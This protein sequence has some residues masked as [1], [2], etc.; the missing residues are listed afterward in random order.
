MEQ[1]QVAE[2]A[3]ELLR[4]SFELYGVPSGTKD[5]LY[6]PLLAHLIEPARQAA[7]IGDVAKLLPPGFFDRHRCVLDLGCGPGTFTIGLNSLGHAAYGIDLDPRKIALAHAHVREGGH[8]AQWCD[9]LIPGDGN[10]LPFESGSFDVVASY[11]VLEHVNDLRSVLCEAVRVTKPGGFLHLQ[12]PDYRYSY[13]T[14]YC[15]PWPRMMPVRQAEAWCQ[16]M[17]RPSGGIGTIYR[18]T[19]PEVVAIL[20]ALDCHLCGVLMREH[21]DNQIH[22]HDGVIPRDPLM[23]APG[24]DLASAAAQ[25]RALAETGNLPK[26]YKTCLEFTILAQRRGVGQQT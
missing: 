1:R 3:E 24:V 26:I 7:R 6:A 18:V 16:A 20:E 12:A 2:I 13:D 14:H 5:P 11:H 17:G 4:E 9:R 10:V 25:L 15:M 21:R 22:P 19:M 8:P 23:F